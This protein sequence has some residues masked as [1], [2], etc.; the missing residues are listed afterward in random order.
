MDSTFSYSFP[1]LRGTQA[2]KEYYVGM[3][4][5][6]V[7]PKIFSFDEEEVGP[8]HRAQRTL[9]KSR[10][11][12]ITSYILN[13]Q[14]DYVFSSLTASVDGDMEFMPYSDDP[15]FSD[16]GRLVISM[17]ARFLINDGQ[18]R[19]AA[20]EEALRTSSELGQE[21]IS[22]VFFKDI[23]LTKSQ[24]MFADLNRHAVNTTSS[25]GILYEHRDQLANITKEIITEIPLMDRY[26]D[27]ERPSLS[28]LSPKIFALNNIFHTNCRILNKKKGEFISDQEKKF[29]KEFWLELC[30][31]MVEWQQVF[32]KEL[33][34]SELRINF[35]NAH[36][37]FLEAMGIIGNYL[38]NNH[39]TDWKK[40]LQ[41]LSAFDWNR[42]NSTEW[43]GRAVGSTGRINKNNDT[44]QLTA[45]LIKVKLNLSLDENELRIEEK[46]MTGSANI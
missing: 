34:P 25:L 4:P 42:T 14:N 1:A 32:R 5:L 21:T 46:L 19:R 2:G 6:R 7:I 24:Q 40:Y 38:Y 31:A 9:N 10:I 28:K 15:H 18:H 36:G 17:D 29:L 33:S 41:K 27:K 22:V 26:T 39:P 20:I 45:N 11:P 3:C 13:N 23:G 44:I 16:I 8:E 30:D 35:I 12:E 37:V 43:L